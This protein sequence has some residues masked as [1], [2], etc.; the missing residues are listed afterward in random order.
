M[1]NQQPMPVSPSISLDIEAPDIQTPARTYGAGSAFSAHL[2]PYFPT[3]YLPQV[4][5]HDSIFFPHLGNSQSVNQSPAWE[6][7]AVQ[8]LP[9]PGGGPLTLTASSPYSMFQSQC[10]LPGVIPTPAPDLN[11]IAAKTP[12]GWDRIHKAM[13]AQGPK[14]RAERG[15]QR[16][17]DFL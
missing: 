15:C 3:P 13:E 16:E 4:G 7:E 2:Q 14:K 12:D 17:S 6:T 11:Q 5:T 8:S 9:D 10:E 1:S